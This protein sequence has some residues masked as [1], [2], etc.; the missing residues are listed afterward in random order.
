M[1]LVELYHY[2]NTDRADMRTNDWFL[3]SS[4]IPIT[5]ILFSYSYFIFRCGPK[6]MENKQPYG[7]HKLVRV[8]NLIQIILNAMTIYLIVDSGWIEDFFIYCVPPNYDPTP[9]G[10]KICAVSYYGLIVRIVDLFE[11]II[12]VL[13]KKNRQISFLHLYHH[14]SSVIM[15]WL[16]V[17]YVSTGMSLTI[18]IVNAIIH[19]IMYTYYL[20]S[21][22][23][24]NI[25]RKLQPFKPLITLA[26]IVQFV[27]LI[28]Y[29]L[30]GLRPACHGLI[31]PAAVM[32]VNLSINLIF[33]YNFY[34]KNYMSKKSK[35]K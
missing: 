13:R 22:Y 5:L 2:L 28:L 12:F 34:R 9:K 25:Q 1:G 16:N 27:F 14:I 29:L 32:F 26:Q 35:A 10:I 11:T 18:G 4:P 17:K 30:H 8:Y 20:L 3:M 33:F 7:L 15:S 21:T 6:F 23:G 24:P 31:I 19:V